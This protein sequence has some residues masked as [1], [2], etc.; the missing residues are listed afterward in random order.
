MGG[1]GQLLRLLYVKVSETLL[2]L[3]SLRS[4]AVE[5]MQYTLIDFMLCRLTTVH[6]NFD[7]CCCSCSS[8]NA[9]T[10]FRNPRILSHVYDVLIILCP[11]LLLTASLLFLFAHLL[12]CL[13][14]VYLKHDARTRP[15]RLVALA[16]LNSIQVSI[17]SIHLDNS[18]Y[19]FI[20]VYYIIIHHNTS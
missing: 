14:A 4:L 15:G 17:P 5:G 2:P 10:P 3:P 1:G 13:V 8:G 16:H 6:L 18:T 11:I 19:T 7:I 12:R 9:V 20:Q